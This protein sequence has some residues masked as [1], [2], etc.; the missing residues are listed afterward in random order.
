MI[1]ATPVWR[2]TAIDSDHRRRDGYQWLG[3]GVHQRR[4]AAVGGHAGP[5]PAARRHVSSTGLARRCT[6]AVCRRDAGVADPQVSETVVCDTRARA[7]S[8]QRRRIR[9]RRAGLDCTPAADPPRRAAPRAGCPRGSSLGAA[10]RSRR[11]IGKPRIGAAAGATVR[12]PPRPRRSAL[13]EFPFA[14]D[15]L[16]GGTVLEAGRVP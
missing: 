11:C 10:P 16:Q 9:A 6:I 12:P 2:V 15:S 7:P 5:C 4:A 8:G 3:V 13:S 14:L 1:A